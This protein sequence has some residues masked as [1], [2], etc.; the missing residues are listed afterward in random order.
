MNLG[1]FALPDSALQGSPRDKRAGNI[2]R[3][4]D[5][6]HSVEQKKKTKMDPNPLSAMVFQ[7]LL[8]I[9]Y[10]VVRAVVINQMS[11]NLYVQYTGASLENC[12]QKQN[13]EASAGQAWAQWM[14]SMLASRE[15]HLMEIAGHQ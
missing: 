4:K 15:D 11:A 14:L 2:S 7:W 9:L 5:R 6:K 10:L 13:Q 8:A 1:F 3:S 12:N